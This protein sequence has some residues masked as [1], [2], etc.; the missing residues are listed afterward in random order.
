L[1]SYQLSEQGKAIVEQARLKKGWTVESSRWQ[2]E[3]SRVIDPNWQGFPYAAGISE[4]TWKRF[5]RGNPIR[6]EAFRA[7][8]QVLEVDWEA[9][10]HW[11][12]I[13]MDGASSAGSDSTVQ[14]S[15]AIVPSAPN[16][17]YIRPKVPESGEQSSPDRVDLTLAPEVP[18]LD[19][20]DPELTTLQQWILQAGA[21]LVMVVG[22]GGMGKTTLVTRLAHQIQPHFQRVVWRSLLNAPPLPDLIADLVRFLSHEREASASL[23]RLLYYLQQHRC[24]LV[25]DN[26]E[27]ILQADQRAGEYQAQYEAYG[28][29]LDQVARTVHQS[30]VLLTS[31]EL[32][33]HLVPLKNLF[34]VYTLPLMGLSPTAGEQIL[35]RFGLTAT[36]AEATVLIQRYDG[37]PQAMAI[38]ASLVHDLYG[39]DLAQFLKDEVILYE[40]IR[41]LLTQQFNRL[42]A[43]EKQVMYWLAV[44]REPIT[45][46]ELKQDISPSPPMAQLVDALTSLQR[47][48]LIQKQATQFSLQ[49]LLMEYVT[50]L[51]IDRIAQELLTQQ[52]ELLIQQ[53]LIKARARHYIRE[54][55]IR[56]I[57]KPIVD[58]LTQ[59][60]ATPL[61][62]QNFFYAAIANLQQNF[63]GR[64]GYGTGNLLNLGCQMQVNLTGCD[65][66]NLAIWQAYL[67]DVNLHNVNCR[68]ANFA[69]S[70][71]AQKLEG[72]LP[73]SFSPDSQLLAAG[74]QHGTILVWRIETG[75]LQCLCQ[76]HVGAVQ[77]L[78]FSADGSVLVTG[79][80]DGTVRIWELQQG[81]CLQ[82]LPD[83]P[84]GVSA[85]AVSEEV[86]LLAVG[87]QVGLI[88]LWRWPGGQVFRDLQGHDGKISALAFW[89][90]GATLLS[91]DDQII[92]QWQIETDQRSTI[93]PPAAEYITFAPQ[94]GLMAGSDGL[95]V[96]LRSLTPDPSFLTLL[97]HTDWIAALS[98]NPTGD[99]LASSSRDGT[100]RLWETIAGQCL[101]TL[102]ASSHCIESLA[103][104]PN[105]RYLASGSNDQQVAVWDLEAGHCVR[106][107]KGYRQLVQ[108]Y[109]CTADFRWLATGCADDL[110]RLWQV[111]CRCC[112]HQLAGHGDWVSAVAFDPNGEALASGG[113]EGSVRVWQVATGDL[114]HLFPGHQDRVATLA[115]IP[116]RNWLA[117]GSGD[118]VYLWDLATGAR[119][120]VL[121]GH[122]GSVRMLAVDPNGQWIWSSGA[123][124]ALYR[125]STATGE[126]TC[127]VHF[128]SPI[129]AI[130]P[131]PS[132]QHLVLGDSEGQIQFLSPET[133][134]VQS[135]LVQDAGPVS[136]LAYSPNGQYLA[137][138][139][140]RALALW[141]ISGKISTELPGSLSMPRWLER[142]HLAEICY[143]CF[144]ADSQQVLS[145]SYDGTVKIWDV[146]SGSPIKISAPGRPYEGLV[147]TGSTGLTPAQQDTLL[148]LGAINF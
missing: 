133:G 3:A 70:V 37:N 7:Y 76:E 123:D 14:G 71:F 61:A 5:R 148:D 130:A 31:R 90:Q 45:A 73:I 52:Y 79:S 144:R 83:H 38:I 84:G 134:E 106:I 97:G 115:F 26:A 126:G 6:T 44:S 147:I 46:T 128:E 101:Q 25:L 51:L 47:R 13:P 137:S 74:D 139:H 19:G 53:A 107:L 117:S 28:Q 66:S 105:D 36:L 135:C 99:R 9:V 131:H 42:S 68:G 102:L 59:H 21:R 114:L 85:V 30:C 4:G 17:L 64:S 60:L 113:D 93:A 118:S 72:R 58:R 111:D 49:P 103:F 62:R 129:T 27:S 86:G 127:L 95:N 63:A 8:C 121:Q 12:P 20:R 140:D 82:V 11:E 10:A 22:L 98:F 23:A 116:Q 48:S 57:L 119:L 104:S 29:F 41:D 122:T 125:W 65:L 109:A 50:A 77:S 120:Q 39:G 146:C 56:L 81:Q 24:L 108:S 80:E 55:Q 69:N 16:R 141:E 15:A 112:A 100:I 143:L 75:S 138:S 32:P 88:R 96:Q 124:R 54:N 92:Y 34:P 89:D 145:A 110:V 18:H 142:D 94:T 1:A 43:L 40:D 33:A 136:A 87:T 67:A 132:G 91:C 2:E 78:T 35:D